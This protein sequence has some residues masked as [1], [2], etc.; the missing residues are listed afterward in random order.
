MRCDVDRR[1]RTLG[2]SVFIL[3]SSI[4]LAL[5]RMVGGDVRSL[6]DA[7]FARKRASF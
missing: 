4:D 5:G 7:R 3:S 1:R 6:G 2:D